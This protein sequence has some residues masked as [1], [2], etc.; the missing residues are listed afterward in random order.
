MSV[1]GQGGDAHVI[2]ILVEVLGVPTKFS[3]TPGS[4]GTIDYDTPTLSTYC[5]VE[6][7]R[8]EEE[9]RL[10]YHQLLYYAPQT[11]RQYK[12]L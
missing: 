6:W 1:L 4:K 2:I 3:T 7:R 9:Q 10:V 5:L 12:E 8:F 11:D